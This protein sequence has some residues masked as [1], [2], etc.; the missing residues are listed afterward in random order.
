MCQLIWLAYVQCA[1]YCGSNLLPHA[2]LWC[3]APQR[4]NTPHL[5]LVGLHVLVGVALD[6]RPIWNQSINQSILTMGLKT[7]QI[8]NRASLV[9]PTKPPSYQS[10]AGELCTL[11]LVW[12]GT[13]VELRCLST[14]HN[15]R[16]SIP[17][18]AY[19]SIS[20]VTVVIKARGDANKAPKFLHQTG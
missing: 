18:W 14:T 12:E 2:L 13:S 19:F 4:C 7:L 20:S 17:L 5:L 15:P 10:A 6:Y 1:V 11:F 3:C 8:P 16:P 9:Q